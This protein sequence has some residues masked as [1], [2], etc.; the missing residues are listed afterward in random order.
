MRPR[1]NVM[2][3]EYD[4]APDGRHFVMIQANEPKTPPT[5]LNVL[6]NWFTDLKRQVAAIQ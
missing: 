1:I 3:I 6:L 2:G 5:E 4:V